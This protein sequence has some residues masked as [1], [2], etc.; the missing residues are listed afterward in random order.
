VI[1]GMLLGFDIL[2][3]RHFDEFFVLK[4]CGALSKQ[5]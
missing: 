3:A 4:K 2:K 1:F 5:L